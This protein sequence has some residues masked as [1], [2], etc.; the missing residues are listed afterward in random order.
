MFYDSISPLLVIRE[1]VKVGFDPVSLAIGVHVSPRL[2]WS[3]LVK[4]TSSAL[5]RMK[6]SLERARDT[7]WPHSCEKCTVHY[8]MYRFCTTSMIWPSEWSTGWQ[9]RLFG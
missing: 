2:L 6:R 9:V 5:A 8:R 7:V 4:V 3:L 1:L